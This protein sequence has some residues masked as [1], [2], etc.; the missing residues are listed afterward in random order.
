MLKKMIILGTLVLN[1]TPVMADQIKGVAVCAARCNTESLEIFA[2]SEAYVGVVYYAEATAENL[3]NTNNCI[4]HAK[5]V[6]IISNRMTDESLQTC[7]DVM[8]SKFYGKKVDIDTA[9]ERSA[10]DADLGT[11]FSVKLSK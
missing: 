8:L 4:A 6:D 2:H 3:T 7:A 11:Y 5:T 1:L 9:T 10:D